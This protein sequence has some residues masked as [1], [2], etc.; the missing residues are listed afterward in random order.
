MGS[1]SDGSY[2][3]IEIV[4]VDDRSTDSSSDMLRQ[5][6]PKIRSESAST[7]AATTPG[8]GHRP[9]RAARTSWSGC[10]RLAAAYTTWDINHPHFSHSF[11]TFNCCSPPAANSGG[12]RR[13]RRILSVPIRHRHNRRTP[14]RAFLRPTL[15]TARAGFLSPGAWSGPRGST[16]GRRGRHRRPVGPSCRCGMTKRSPCAGPERIGEPL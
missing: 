11:D 13:E 4:V 2:S 6:V 9:N 3:T 7:A 14:H 12:V 10:G 15:R 16:E 8:P 5:F 1:C